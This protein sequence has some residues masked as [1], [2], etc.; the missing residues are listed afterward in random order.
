MLVSIFLKGMTKNLKTFAE[1]CLY[2]ITF[3]GPLKRLGCLGLARCIFVD[4]NGLVADTP[5]SQAIQATLFRY[6]LRPKV[7]SMSC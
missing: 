2:V 7:V 6:Q 5:E 4:E 1:T 3:G